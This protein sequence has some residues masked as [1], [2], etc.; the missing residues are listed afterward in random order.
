MASKGLGDNIEK[1]ITKPLGI[2]AVVDKV[3]EI[4]GVPCNCEGRKNQLNKWWP[5]KGNLYQDEYEFLEL[6]FGTY[7][8]KNLKSF[9]E[10][11]MIYKIYNRVNKQKDKPTSC[12]SCL[13]KI[14]EN[15]RQL[16]IEY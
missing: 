6:F 1:Y 10:R 5:N 8:G 4:T 2:K 13:N 15:V 7:N 16:Y 9:D 12:A 11:D 14:I 3:S